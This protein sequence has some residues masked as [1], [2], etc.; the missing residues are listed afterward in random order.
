MMTVTAEDWT[1]ALRT[2]TV[3][4]LRRNYWLCESQLELCAKD[5]P[6]LDAASAELQEWKKYYLGELVRRGKGL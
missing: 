6:R 4:H 3:A 2:M 1:E 5:R